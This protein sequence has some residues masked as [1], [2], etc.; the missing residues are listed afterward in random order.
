METGNPIVEVQ[1]I[2]KSFNGVTV[3]NDV[4]FDVYPGKVHALLGENGAGKSTLV[5]VIS[6]VFPPTAGTLRVEG[7][8]VEIRNPLMARK[9]G[10]AL[11]HHRIQ[12]CILM[13]DLVKLENHLPYSCGKRID[14]FLICT[15]DYYFW[16]QI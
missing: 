11:I 14:C 13:L 16:L 10:I 6:G 1:G 15:H 2:G 4:T 3:L 12:L 5:N 8:Q 9:L 7:K